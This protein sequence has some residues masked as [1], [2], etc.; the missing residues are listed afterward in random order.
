LLGDAFTVL[1]LLV[2]L[3]L[4]PLLDQASLGSHLA[5]LLIRMA[6]IAQARTCGEQIVAAWRE[7]RGV[8]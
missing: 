7:R 4:D 2:E 8:K 6:R 5:Q 1:P 3:Q